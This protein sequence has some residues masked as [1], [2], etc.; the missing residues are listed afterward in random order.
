[1]HCFI[2][3]TF[4]ADV[5]ISCVAAQI[6]FGLAIYAVQIG[7]PVGRLVFVCEA[8]CAAVERSHT[9]DSLRLLKSVSNGDSVETCIE[10]DIL[11][12]SSLLQLD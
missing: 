9:L 8:L 6:L 4:S 2:L 10:I 11:A 3:L 12:I 7:K 1:M 5:D